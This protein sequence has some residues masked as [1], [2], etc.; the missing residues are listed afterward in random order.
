MGQGYFLI[1][2]EDPEDKILR[3]YESRVVQPKRYSLGDGPD[4]DVSPILDDMGF[5]RIWEFP[6]RGFMY[7]AGLD[8]SEGIDTGDGSTDNHVLRILRRGIEAEMLNRFWPN[9]K[10]LMDNIIGE[11]HRPVVV[12]V[13]V[14][15]EDL[16]PLG[17]EVARSCLWYNHAHIA[18]ERNNSGTGLVDI[19]LWDL[20]PK[21]LIMRE[22]P[23]A[24]VKQKPGKKLGFRTGPTNKPALLAE[25]KNAMRQDLY[26]D[27]DDEF[28]FE[29]RHFVNLGGK[30]GA[31]H[32]FHDDR[33]MSQALAWWA[34]KNA[35][36]GIPGN[37]TTGVVPEKR[38]VVPLH[39]TVGY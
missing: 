17:E 28:L 32:R 7:C 38:V 12:A 5:W 8:T 26:D 34:H 20:Y 9:E 11:A 30:L 10:S 19:S 2:G 29:C 6:K 31:E 22:K 25:L 27:F 15:K 18:P 35:P 3:L 1:I 37:V 16:K 4:G 14:S 36:K 33:V 24:N 39:R 13:Y 23:L 21:H